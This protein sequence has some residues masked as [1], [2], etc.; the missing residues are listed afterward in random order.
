MRGKQ[1]LWI[2]GIWL[3]AGLGLIAPEAWAQF[4]GGN[5]PMASVIT[6]TN[7]TTEMIVSVG[8]AA[9]GL[10]AAILFMLALAGK[11]AWH[12]AIMAV[13]AAAGFTGLPAIQAWLNS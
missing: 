13:I 9:T 10:V 1:A 11:A 6:K 12:W 3:V 8:K 4:G 5:N 2:V 7:E